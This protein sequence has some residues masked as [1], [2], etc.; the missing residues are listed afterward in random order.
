MLLDWGLHLTGREEGAKSLGLTWHASVP[1][2]K[3]PA[4]SM[5]G[6]KAVPC[7]SEAEQRSGE[8]SGTCASCRKLEYSS[9]PRKPKRLPHT[10]RDVSRRWGRGPGCV[11]FFQTL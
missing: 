11:R 1:P 7:T 9:A 8:M 3:K 10:P 6:A 4:Q 2:S 5:P